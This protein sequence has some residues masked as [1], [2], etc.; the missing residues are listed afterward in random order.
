M[1]AIWADLQM[2]GRFA[3]GL[4]AYV[5]E[6]ASSEQA[7]T[8]IAR[9]IQSR[10][11][12]FLQLAERAVFARAGSSPYAALF[13]HAGITFEDLRESV[14]RHGLE[15]ALEGLLDAGV[16]LTLDEFKGKVP[17]RRG[18][19]ELIPAPANCDN[20]L[21]AR[22]FEAASGGSTG[23]RRRMVIDLEL[24]RYETALHRVFV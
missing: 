19:V 5:R 21:L 11:Q 20:P 10:E 4:R 24:L 22:H 8:I 7:R 9:S 23:V 1:T 3:A 6:G 17:V 14:R 13:H 15:G 12:N 18:G 2:L 16:F